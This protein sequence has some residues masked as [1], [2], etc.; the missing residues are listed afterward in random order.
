M[1]RCTDF[2]PVGSFPRVVK[3]SQMSGLPNGSGAHGSLGTPS[4]LIIILALLLLLLCCCCFLDKAAVLR[5]SD[6]CSDAAGTRLSD[7]KA[8]QLPV[9]LSSSS[10]AV[11]WG[12]IAARPAPSSESL[13]GAKTVCF[14]KSAATWQRWGCRCLVFVHISILGRTSK[15]IVALR[16]VLGPGAP[17]AVQ[18]KR[19]QTHSANSH[20]CRRCCCLRCSASSTVVSH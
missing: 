10:S 17:D 4:V 20:E 2:S 1:L 7:F 6:R 3:V 19:A 11:S 12:L 13:K 9:F 15:S 8:A 18:L 5:L 16:N 14:S